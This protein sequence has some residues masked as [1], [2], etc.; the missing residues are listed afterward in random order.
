MIENEKQKS[1]KKAK[2]RI[3]EIEQLLKDV[4]RPNWI[5]LVTERNSLSVTL[6]RMKQ[7]RSKYERQKP[8]INTVSLRKWGI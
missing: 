7:S 6:K 5:S 2:A 8:Y 4:S 1:I 3:K